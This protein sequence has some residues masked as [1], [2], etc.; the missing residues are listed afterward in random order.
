M[1]VMTIMMSSINS[2]FIYMLENE[3]KENMKDV[4]QKN[5]LI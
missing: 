3:C 5:L 2:V 4:Q 1:K